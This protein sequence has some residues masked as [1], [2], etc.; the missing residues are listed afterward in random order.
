MAE[1]LPMAG[2]LL[3]PHY[4]DHCLTAT[5]LQII[6]TYQLNPY[7]FRSTSD[8]VCNNTP[9]N[10]WMPAYRYNLNPAEGGNSKNRKTE[11]HRCMIEKDKKHNEAN[12]IEIHGNSRAS[13]FT[14][15]QVKDVQ[16]NLI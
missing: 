1:K 9:N 6:V 2:R 11:V 4:Y 16:V 3:S 15:E 7:L 14:A 12:L 13:K 5:T 10:Q 8:V